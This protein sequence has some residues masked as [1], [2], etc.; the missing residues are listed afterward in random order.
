MRDERMR[1]AEGEIESRVQAVEVALS[2]CWGGAYG[3]DINKLRTHALVV[4]GYVD[5]WDH[6]ER[7]A[8]RDRAK[9]LDPESGQR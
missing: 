2:Q 7:T 5:A 9:G 3:S 4:L 8:E 1:H 6:Q